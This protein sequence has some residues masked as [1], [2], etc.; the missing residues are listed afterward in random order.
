MIRP[1][2]QIL[3][4]L[5]P[6]YNRAACLPALYRSLQEQTDFHFEWI[7]VDDGSTD[8]SGALL[9]GWE[10]T[11]T[12]F[13]VT[14]IHKENGGKHT[15]VNEGVRLAGGDFVFVVDSDDTLTPDAV[16]KVR[17]W[18]AEIR[19]RKDLVG[20]ASSCGYPD[21]T[22]LGHFPEGKEWV[23]AS[24]IERLKLHMETDMAEIY[25]TETLKQFPFPIFPGERFLGESLIW[26]EIATQGYKLRWYRDIVYISEYRPD[27]LT[28]NL[29]DNIRQCFEGFTAVKKKGWFSYPFP[30]NWKALV[31]YLDV[32]VALGKSR[33]EIIRRMDISQFQFRSALMLS[34]I[35]GILKRQRAVQ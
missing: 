25:R 34:R 15:A 3:T 4:L 17:R 31:S 27:G 9:D 33:D 29:T 6:V 14:V 23:D 19:D 10:K 20:V 24:N 30:F 16:E 8:E 12:A 22:R 11:E 13:P 26:D 7:A 32:A 5:T 21:G 1:E 2:S 35:K 28:Q 18:C